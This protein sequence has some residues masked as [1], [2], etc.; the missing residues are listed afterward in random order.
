MEEQAKTNF[1]LKIKPDCSV[2]DKDRSFSGPD[3]SAIEFFIEFKREP[4]DDPFATV[5]SRF[6]N[7]TPS[8]LGPPPNPFVKTSNEAVLTR[9]QITAYTTSHMSAQYRTH[10]FSVLICGSKA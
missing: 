4:E 5:M 7:T 9:G 10:I 8:S 6:M 3:S 2:F 1:P